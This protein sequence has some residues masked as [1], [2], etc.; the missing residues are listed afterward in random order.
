MSTKTRELSVRSQLLAGV[1]LV[2]GIRGVGALLA[3]EKS[4]ASDWPQLGGPN[5]NNIAPDSPKLMDAW[6][7]DGPPQVWKSDWIPACEEGGFSSP[8]VAAGRVFVYATAKNQ[9]PGKKPYQVVTP[10]ILA[11]AGWLADLPEDLAKQIEAARVSTN[12]PSSLGWEWFNPAKA[13]K[14]GALEEFLAKKP[15]LDKYIKDFIATLPPADAAK[16]GD[17]IRKRLCIDVPRNKWGLPNGLSWDQLVKLSKMQD[18]AFTGKRIWEHELQKR[19]IDS[20]LLFNYP[21]PYGW[22]QIYTWSDTIFCL[23]AATGR[24][25]WKKE[26]PFDVAT[27]KDPNVQ[28]WCFDAWGVSSTPAVSNGKVYVVCET[29]LRCFAAKDGTLLWEAKGEPEHA[30]PIVADGI[31]Y[32]VGTAYDAETGAVRW[33]HPLWD[34][35]HR[36]YESE[37][38]YSSPSLFTAGGKQ[39]LITTDYLDTYNCKTV[40]LDLETGKHLWTAKS[41]P[42]GMI[43]GDILVAPP[44][45]GSSGL[46]AY[47]MTPTG[48]EQIW[49]QMVSGSG[50]I[51]QDHVYLASGF[52]SCL[53]LKTG[54]CNWKKPV[55]GG[56]AECC[57]SILA[58]GKILTPRGE[59]HQLTK[60]FG[61]LTYALSMVKAS[62]E[63]YTE[64]GFFNPRMCM[65]TTPAIVNGRLFLRLLDGIACYDLQEHGIYL[66]GVTVAKDSIAFNF[67]QT[68]GGISGDPTD[69]VLSA[70]CGGRFKNAIIRGESIVMGIDVGFP[71]RI[72][73]LASNS[74]TGKNGGPVPA[75]GWNEWRNLRYRKAFENTVMLSSDRWLQ[76]DGRW[77]KPEAFTV[78][79]AKVT[80]VE[81]DP[82]GKSVNL[83]TD[84]TWKPGDAVSVTYASFP[85]TQ[86]A[87]RRETLVAKV[88][89]AQRA[90]AKFLT[91]DVTTTGA[92]KGIYGA[93]GAVIAGDAGT[94]GAP[95]CAT[96][97]L[98][99]KKDEVPWAFTP[100]SPV[101][102]QFASDEKRRS[103]RMWNAAE[104]IDVGVDITDGREHQVALFFP[105]GCG[106]LTVDVIDAD[107]RSVLDTRSYADKGKEKYLLWNIQGPVIL[108]VVCTKLD[109]GHSIWMGGVL[110]D[111]AAK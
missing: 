83:I 62:P 34:G 56:V 90:A 101:A 70:D 46:T 25:L 111:P 36:K 48:A 17:Y 89:V 91:N 74:M 71:C 31:V 108:R 87:P 61:D 105:F 20:G 109:E 32:Y 1:L 15:E 53:D 110:L 18:T 66:D 103:N 57:G 44:V 63:E 47:R 24:T 96:V 58:D 80:A 51:Y 82:K 3:A 95:T 16:Y 81:L 9:L 67:K 13:R 86:G 76:Q 97:T 4:A 42:G 94:N 37:A 69:V 68:G 88:V 75:F 60:N 27:V 54:Q 22:N 23:D 73:C 85:V 77:S 102:P 64:L 19:G 14:A 72:S 7:K 84:K 39:C 35:K 21:T 98:S 26:Y 5:R 43:S 49:K 6:P 100:E 78:A 92:W 10:E 65:M 106:S 8:V 59:C 29:G 52:Y 99:G 93:E 2:L 28:W 55:P 104:L 30:S 33:K 11:D 12:R 40:C 50:P 38:R 45:Y 79:G 107:T 41:P